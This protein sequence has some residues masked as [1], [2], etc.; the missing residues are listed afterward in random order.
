MQKQGLPGSAG[1]EWGPDPGLRRPSPGEAAG[2]RRAEQSPRCCRDVS[3]GPALLRTAVNLLGHMV[4]SGFPL[5]SV[6]KESTC[7]AGDV[8]S[9]P[10]SGRCLGR[11][12]GDPLQYS[13]LENPIDRGS[14]GGYSPWGRKESNMTERLSTHSHTHSLSLLQP[15]L[16]TIC[17]LS[18]QVPERKYS[19]FTWFILSF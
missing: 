4:I 18:Y 19:I 6:S 5:D 17:S 13:C 3:E 15:A 7:N 1:V 16:K 11:G 2:R 12:N 10:G 8:G 14:W 9:T